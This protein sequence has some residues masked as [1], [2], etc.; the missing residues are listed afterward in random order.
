MVLDDIGCVAHR[1]NRR[2]SPFQ[3][4]ESIS[5]DIMPY[6]D[7][8]PYRRIAFYPTASLDD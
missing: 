2:V 3:R 5:A 4:F 7:T 1:S 8:M 6:A